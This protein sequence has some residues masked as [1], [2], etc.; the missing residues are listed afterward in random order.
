MSVQLDQPDMGGDPYYS[1]YYA[2]GMK[3]IDGAPSEVVE[4]TPD[5]W[6]HFP[7]YH[8]VRNDD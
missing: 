8:P 2:P 3:Q 5:F 1:L 4:L 6:R 7:P